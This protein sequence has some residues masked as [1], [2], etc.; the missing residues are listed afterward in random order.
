MFLYSILYT[1][2]EL[3]QQRNV[4]MT[5]SELTEEEKKNREE[6]AQLFYRTLSINHPHV[7]L[8]MCYEIYDKI[9]EEN[10]KEKK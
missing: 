5:K 1:L 2:G 4:E 9:I 10:K 3:L 6:A 8:D 7:T